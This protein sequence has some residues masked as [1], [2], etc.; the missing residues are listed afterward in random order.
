[1][2]VIFCDVN[3]GAMNQ[4]IYLEQDGVIAP[5][6]NIPTVHLGEAITGLAYGLD[7]YSIKLGGPEGYLMKTIEEV[8]ETEAMS[9]GLDRINIEVMN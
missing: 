5:I 7:A 8:K 2:S 3:L 1:M 9:Y 4:T 6:A